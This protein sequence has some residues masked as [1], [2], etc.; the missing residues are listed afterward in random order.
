MPMKRPSGRR[1]GVQEKR[2]CRVQHHDM[3]N[4]F[5]VSSARKVFENESFHAFP[6][7][8]KQHDLLR[9]GGMEQDVRNL[10]A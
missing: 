6:P 3:M 7:D 5:A 9:G 4:I 8:V 10:K 1:I 2:H